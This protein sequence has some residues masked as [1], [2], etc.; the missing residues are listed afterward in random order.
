MCNDN[1]DCGDCD[2]DNKG[3]DE[4]GDYYE[5]VDDVGDVDDDTSDAMPMYDDD[6]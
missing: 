6:S 3:D 1:D 2:V 4:S 5:D